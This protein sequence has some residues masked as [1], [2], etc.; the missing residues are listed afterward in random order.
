VLLGVGSRPD[1]LAHATLV[2]HKRCTRGATE[3]VEVAWRDFT[4]L[5]EELV[6]ELEEGRVDGFRGQ[7][8]SRVSRLPAG[9]LSSLPRYPARTTSGT[10]SPC[11][12]SR[13]ATPR[14]ETSMSHYLL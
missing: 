13:P 7:P 10:P 8:S 2:P 4:D 5:V 11:V 1:V 9:L 6:E 3:L 12:A 14:G